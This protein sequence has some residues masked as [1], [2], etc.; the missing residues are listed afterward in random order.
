MSTGKANLQERS[1]VWKAARPF[2]IGWLSPSMATCCIQPID[3]VKV[4]IQLQQGNVNTNPFSIAS[5]ML[6][7][8]G[9]SVFYRGLSAALFRQLTYGTTRLGIFRTLTNKVTPEGGTAADIPFL[10]K[11]GC[12]LTAGGIGALIGTPAEVALVRM[13]ADTVAPVEQRRGYKNVVDALVKIGYK[14]GLNGYFTGAWPT[15][16]RGL[17]INVGML[18]T[19]DQF[20]RWNA[21]WAGGEGSQTNR[22]VSGALSGWTAATMA[23]PFDFIKTRLQRMTPNPDG[24]YPYTGVLDCARKVAKQEG[25]MAL[26]QG[27]GTFVIRI[28]P[29]IMLTWVFMDN[30][31]DLLTNNGL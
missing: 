1:A 16:V 19:F 11:M 25:I 20:K 7:T 29:H 6:A 3:M 12:S 22:F 18:M 15:I 9:V 30:L 31:K 24:T 28:T 23:L 17:S 13:Q 2:F 10:T 26:Y 21:G 5:K 14:E 27:Y 8:E 4:R